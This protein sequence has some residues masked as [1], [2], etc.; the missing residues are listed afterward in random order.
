MKRCNLFCGKL[1][2]LAVLLC[3]FT[4]SAV[5]QEMIKMFDD[6]STFNAPMLKVGHQ[7]MTGL[8]GD[9]NMDA[10]FDVA[11]VTSLISAILN[12]YDPSGNGD[13]NL[14]QEV[15]VADVTMLI[16]RILNSEAPSVEVLQGTLDDVYRSMRTAGWATTGNTHQT[17]GILAQTLIA[18]VMGDDMIMGAAGSGWFWYEASY[19]VKQRYTSTFWTSYFLWNSYYT[20]IANANYLLETTQTMPA[21]DVKYIRGQAYAIRAYSYFML[22]QWFARTYKGH[23]S[24]PCVPIY[25]GFTFN[26]STGKPRSTVSQVYAQ[27]DADIA[28]AIDLLNGTTQQEVHHIGYAVAQGLQARIALVKEDW[29]TAYSAAT[30]AINTSGKTVQ[31]I[32]DFKGLNDAT[33]GNVMW[34]AVIPVEEVGMYASFFSHLSITKDAYGTRAPKQISKWLY[35]KM[36]ATDAR[37]AWWDPASGYSTGGYAQQKFEFSNAETWEGDYIYMRIEEMYLTRAEAACRMD[38]TNTARN[39]LNTLMSKRVTGYSTTKTGTA[40]GTLTTDETGSLLEEILIQ[41]RLELWGE[42]GR[43]YTIRRLHQGFGRST[44][45]GWNA[46]LTAGHAWSDP[47]CYAWVMTIPQS[48]FNGNPNMD[49]QV[50][51]N[52]MGDYSAAG[53]HISLSERNQSLVTARESV[54][55]PITVTRAVTRGAYTA[56]LHV[57]ASGGSASIGTAEFSNG[58]ATTTATLNLSRLQLGNEYTFI[59][60]LSDADQDSYDPSQGTQITSMTITVQCVNGNPSVQHVSFESSSLSYETQSVAMSVPVVLTRATTQGEYRTTIAIEGNPDNV[61]LDSPE[62]IVFA[63]GSSTA[64]V[65]VYFNPLDVNAPN[66]C[67]LRITDTQGAAGGANQTVT[68][69]VT[70]LNSEQ[71]GYATVADYTFASDGYQ[72]NVA[73]YHIVGTEEYYLSNLFYSLYGDGQQANWHFTLDSDGNLTPAEGFWNYQLSGYSFMYDSVNYSNYCYVERSGEVYTVHYLLAE[74][75]V[76]KYRGTMDVILD[77]W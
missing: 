41:R 31:N 11:D 24:D 69:S 27:I 18:E 50:D 6:P 45:D 17:F 74:G 68:I 22:A 59:V 65:W 14:D 34:G 75:D 71:V 39:S 48:E 3:G 49:P 70:R 52:P 63:D 25:D 8:P 77:I 57:A 23:E 67:V 36:S 28:Q 42:D 62:T 55:I 12:D 20:W 4:T 13:V 26:G 2:W 44:E 56:V 72:T 73:I 37:R 47:E 66:S 5:S 61:Q 33:A 7:W 58:S 43:I 35:N 9:M 53:M 15:D 46:Q 76:P 16:N 21:A 51:Q 10:Q 30:R 64:T 40:L 54:S 1:F 29:E 60:T 38:L 32:D 19:S